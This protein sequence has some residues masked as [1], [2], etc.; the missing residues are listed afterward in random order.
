MFRLSIFFVMIMLLMIINPL[1]ALEDTGRDRGT[2]ITEQDH[3]PYNTNR[4][5]NRGEPLFQLPAP[6][7]LVADLLDYSSVR[8]LWS[9][10]DFEGLEIIL[11]GYNIYRNEEMINPA[12]VLETDFVDCCLIPGQINSYYVTALYDVGESDGSNIVEIFVTNVEEES[13][14]IVT[15]LNANYP[16]PFN[17]ETV[18]SFSLS[19]P[20]RVVIEIFNSRG[21]R[22]R[23]L[24]EGYFE[25]GSHTLT[26][27]GCDDTGNEVR[28]GIFLY[29]MKS[30]DFISSRKMMMLK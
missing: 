15:R 21:Q 11:I 8:L 30:G 17:P 1:L 23:R 25:S 4:G 22:I 16:N 24:T 3:Q 26:W 27:D 12:P 20:G 2:D 10:P 13:I 5:E 7:D 14:P 19:E 9:E 28:S 18:I 6:I 29:R